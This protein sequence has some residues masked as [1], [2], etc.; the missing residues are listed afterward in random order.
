[1]FSLHSVFVSLVVGVPDSPE[2]N[3]NDDGGVE[4]GDAHCLRVSGCPWSHLEWC[5]E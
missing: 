4:G 2:E 3:R 5:L 1:M